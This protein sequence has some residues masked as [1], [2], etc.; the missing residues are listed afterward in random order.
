[1]DTAAVRSW[2]G[3]ELWVETELLELQDT[4]VT[5]QSSHEH[6]HERVKGVFQ[7]SNQEKLP[8]DRNKGH[9]SPGATKGL[10]SNKMLGGHHIP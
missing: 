8:K 4:P 3:D 9:K 6:E 7:A 5:G 1:M 2:E 10:N